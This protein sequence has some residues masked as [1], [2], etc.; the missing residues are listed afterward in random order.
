MKAAPIHV[1]VSGNWP[2]IRN[3]NTVAQTSELE[4]NGATTLAGA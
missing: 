2:Q 3:P 1:A 4:E